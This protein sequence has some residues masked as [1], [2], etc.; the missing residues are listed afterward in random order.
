MV[1]HKILVI[2]DDYSLLRLVQIIL[3]RGGY[4]VSAVLSSEEGRNQIQTKGPFSAIVVDLMMPKESGFDFLKWKDVQDEAVKSLPVIIVTAKNL[5]HEEIEFLN[6]RSRKIIAKGMN[7]AES[8]VK[9][10]KSILSDLKEDIQQ[11]LL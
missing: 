2:D 11:P 8:I 9:E 3:G 1:K 10:V 5:N 4:D 6:A 7:Y